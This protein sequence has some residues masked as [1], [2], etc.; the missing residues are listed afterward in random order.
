MKRRIRTVAACLFLTAALAGC[1][2]NGDALYK[3]GVAK[4]EAGQY[5][6]AA[7]V[8]K[9]GIDENVRLAE[10]YRGLGIASFEQGDYEP[11]VTMLEQS[12]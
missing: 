10:N 11:A 8:F 7:A 6:Q 4:L 3:D 9:Q 1:G 12:L 5:E 2:Q